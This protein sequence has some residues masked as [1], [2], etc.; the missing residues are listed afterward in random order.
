MG[1]KMSKG[2]RAGDLNPS[3]T[4]NITNAALIAKNWTIFNITTPA[5]S[6]LQLEYNNGG[7][8]Y[9][10]SA[11]WSFWS[12]KTPPDSY[13]KLGDSMSWEYDQAQPSP[14]IF[15]KATWELNWF[16]KPATRYT[17]IFKL[18]GC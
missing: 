8:C 18:G 3:F 9:G 12:V 1:D 5:A 16:A 7:G 6:N 2:Y 13:A 14:Q 15:V 11:R 17:E 4:S 10:T